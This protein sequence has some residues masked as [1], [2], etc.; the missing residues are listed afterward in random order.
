[1][2]Y[3]F[4]EGLVYHK[5]IKYHYKISAQQFIYHHFHNPPPHATLAKQPTSTDDLSHNEPVD[6]RWNL[7]E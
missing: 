2:I 1:M 7:Q 5:K 6:Y 4:A 3:R